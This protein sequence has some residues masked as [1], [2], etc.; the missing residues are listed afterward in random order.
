MSSQGKCR[1]GRLQA[2]RSSVSNAK[3]DSKGGTGRSNCPQRKSCAQRKECEE[4]CPKEEVVSE[5][6]S[7][8]MIPK[9]VFA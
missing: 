1:E 2:L 9:M 3:E 4:A 7:R 8:M 5:A 6:A